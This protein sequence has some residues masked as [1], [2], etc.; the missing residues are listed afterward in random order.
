MLLSASR[1]GSSMVACRSL[2]TVAPAAPPRHETYREKLQ[3]LVDRDPHVRK[4][5]QKCLKGERVADNTETELKVRSSLRLAGYG[6]VNLCLGAGAMV[7]CGT[8]PLIATSG[9]A[10][11]DLELLPVYGCMTGV[12][13]FTF[14]M[15]VARLKTVMSVHR[16]LNQLC[17]EIDHSQPSDRLQ[18]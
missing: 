1:F 5:V 16:Q 12:T 14:G 11:C 4:F 2:S 6:A 10:T 18:L 9:I 17:R 15:A 3:L 7:L 13:V 8:I